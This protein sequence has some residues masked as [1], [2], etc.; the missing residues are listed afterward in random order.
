MTVGACDA[1]QRVSQA[2]QQ[3]NTPA[4]VHFKVDTGLHRIGFAP[5]TAAEQ[6]V[7][8]TALPGIALE[9]LYTH[10]AL[11]NTQSDQAQQAAFETVRTGLLAKEV[12]IPMAHML[13]SI[14][15]TRYPQW[16]YDAVRVGAML[17]GNGAKILQAATPIA[18][19][20]PDKYNA[21]K[22]KADKDFKQA[23]EYLTKAVELDP[24]DENSK[25][26]LASINDIL[27]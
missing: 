5:D 23:K 1:A 19:S 10:L 17:Y 15:I 26:I 9:G 2:A 3:T 12:A 16:Q 6:I 11:H 20:E 21:E 8:C 13:D 25:K 7:R 14:G 18:T 22:A 27:K 4:K 24:K